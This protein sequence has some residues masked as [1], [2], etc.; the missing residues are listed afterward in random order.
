MMIMTTN[1]ADDD[2]DMDDTV[3]GKSGLKKGGFEE[4]R[5]S[6]LS[7]QEF[8]YLLSLFNEAGFHFS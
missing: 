8:L 7:Y 5:F 1:G 2:E 4:S 3:E 6:K